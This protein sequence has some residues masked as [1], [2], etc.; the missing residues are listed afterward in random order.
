M[1]V[2]GIVDDSETIRLKEF[3]AQSKSTNEVAKIIR[4][5]SKFANIITKPNG[6]EFGSEMTPEEETQ[7]FEGMTVQQYHEQLGCRR[8]LVPCPLNCL[9]WVSATYL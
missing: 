9:E 1:P 6:K 3:Q 7:T 8:R 5:K 4:G 2:G